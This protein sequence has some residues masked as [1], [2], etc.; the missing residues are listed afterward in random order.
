MPNAFPRT[1]ENLPAGPTSTICKK[2]Q[3][4]SSINVI[5]ENIEQNTI[6]YEATENSDSSISIDFEYDASSRDENIITYSNEEK[7]NK[8]EFH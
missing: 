1:I 8:I 5:V 6:S 3:F 7:N 4:L 2:P